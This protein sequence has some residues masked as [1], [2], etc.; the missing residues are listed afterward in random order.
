MAHVKICFKCGI[1]KSSNY[2]YKHKEMADG[3]LGKCKEC[4]KLDTRVH[5]QIHAD[6]YRAYK[7]E[8][9]KPDGKYTKKA[10]QE[11]YGYSAAHNA[12]KRAIKSG[13]LQKMPCEMCGTRNWIHAHHDDYRKPLDVMWLCPTHHKARHAFLR[14]LNE[15]SQPSQGHSGC[16]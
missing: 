1:R 3:F 7:A 10:R 16:S 9:Y 14:Y 5:R 2:F 13:R 12:T 15:N 6:Y 8:H 4:T 11:I